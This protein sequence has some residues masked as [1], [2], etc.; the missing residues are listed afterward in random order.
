[1]V[2]S[3]S[4]PS[5]RQ[6]RYLSLALSTSLFLRQ[7]FIVPKSKLEN[8]GEKVLE[9]DFSSVHLASSILCLSMLGGLC[10]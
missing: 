3:L 7:L 10:M 5:P 9:M 8:A 6:G 4:E 2:L 1:M